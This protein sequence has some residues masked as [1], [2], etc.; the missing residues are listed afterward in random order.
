MQPRRHDLVPGKA[1]L[2]AQQVKKLAP[3][4]VIAAVTFT[5][6]HRGNKERDKKAQQP[7]PGKK[8]IHKAH[9][10]IKSGPDP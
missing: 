7:D 3:A 4:A 8:N 9:E 5:A 2:F 1:E 10:Q 6:P